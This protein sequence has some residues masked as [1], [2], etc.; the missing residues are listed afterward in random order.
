MPID[1]AINYIT[2]AVKAYY[3]P[4]LCD[5]IKNTLQP[6]LNLDPKPKVEINFFDEEETYDNCTVQ[7]LTNSVTGDISVG[8]W[9]NE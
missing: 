4:D 5:K 7:V 8:W 2:E 1:E 3:D 6:L 9:K